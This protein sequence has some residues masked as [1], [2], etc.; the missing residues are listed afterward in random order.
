MIK[1]L[2][3]DIKNIDKKIIKI[4]LYG[5]KFS[6]LISL[7]AIYILSLYNTYPFS[8]VAYLSGL[9]VFKLS[10]TCLVSFFI[11]GFAINK[12]KI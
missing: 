11:C 2:L 5:F 3:E 9:L 12:I 8:H 1:T 4:M 6:L 10:L 7:L